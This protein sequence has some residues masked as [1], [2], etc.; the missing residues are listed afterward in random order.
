MT[1]TLSQ[2]QRIAGDVFGVAPDAI[3]PEDCPETMER[4]DSIQHLNFVLALEE[5]F[6]VTLS[7]DEMDEIRSVG[8]AAAV[9]ARKA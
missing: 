1:T 8:A 3:R 9:V 7:P 6:G 5:H 2:V 4:W